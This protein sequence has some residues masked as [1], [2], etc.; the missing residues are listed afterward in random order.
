MD[1]GGDWIRMDSNFDNI[2]NGMSTMFKISITEGW[3]DIMWHLI[4]SVDE[5]KIP[6]RDT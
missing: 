3:L 1:Y 6:V 5:G 2:W 4:D